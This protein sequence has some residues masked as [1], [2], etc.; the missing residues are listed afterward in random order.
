MT[1]GSLTVKIAL[2]LV[3]LPPLFETTTQKTEP[4]SVAV[5]AGVT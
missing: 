2:L 1:G 3:T 5:V 4:L